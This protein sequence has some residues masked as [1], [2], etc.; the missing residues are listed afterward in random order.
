M[1]QLCPG[2]ESRLSA[3]VHDNIPDT[4]FRSNSGVAE[5]P[6]D[7]LLSLARLGASYIGFQVRVSL[8][9]SAPQLA[10]ASP[11]F[12]DLLFPGGMGF[13]CRQMLC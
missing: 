7:V 4:Q 11:G 8:G 3:G 13:Y 2:C 12:V 1:P 5:Q 10:Q 6:R 9:R